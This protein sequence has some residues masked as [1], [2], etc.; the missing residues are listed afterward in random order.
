MAMIEVGA[1][2]PEFELQN[3]HGAAIALNRLRG[4]YVVIYFYP[5]AAT[6]GCTT[7]ACGLRDSRAEIAER[8]ARVLGISPDPVRKLASFADKYALEF[9][10]L[11]DPDHVVAELYGAWGP[12]KF[13]G[14][15]FDGILR[16]TVIVDPEGRVAATM[17]TVKTQTHATDV[18]VRLDGLKS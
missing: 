7:Q 3:Q 12:K 5:K 1:P 9:D 10:L 2:A 14:R 11:S 4:G 16:S 17:P 8:G 18:L 15:A 13:M 6:P